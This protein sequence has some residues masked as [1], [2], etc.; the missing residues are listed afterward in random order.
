MSQHP[1]TDPTANLDRAARDRRIEDLE[2]RIEELEAIDSA[3]LGSFGTWDW[4][5]CVLGAVIVPAAA[6]WWFAE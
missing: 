4:I 3:Q 1:P 2:R 6:L 5:I